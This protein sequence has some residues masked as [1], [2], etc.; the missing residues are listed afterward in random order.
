MEEL[1]AYRDKTLVEELA[2]AITDTSRTPAVF[3]EVCGTHTM[4]IQR[5]GLRSLLPAHTE[6]ISGPGCPVCVTETG[7]LD[8]AIAY[9]RRDEVTIATFGDMLRVPGS[10]S[11]L[12]RERARGADV[13]VVYS[14]LEAVALARES[15]E[16]Q[17]VFLGI[18][19]E[20]TAPTTA[21]AVRR[22][23]REGLGNFLVLS[24]H[25]LMKPAM[26]ALME[27]G[28]AIHG[29][30][31][32][33]HVSVVTGTAMYEE[34]LSRYGVSC[35]VAGFEPV[36]ILRGVYL[37][38]RSIEEAAPTVAIAYRRAVTAAGNRRAQEMMREVFE[39]CDTRWRGIGRI[40]HSGLD[41]REAY[42]GHDARRVAP[43]EVPEAREPDGCICGAV[44][45]GAAR[46]QEC[47][48][49]AVECTPQTPVGACMVSSEGTCAAYYRYGAAG[50][51]ARG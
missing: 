14:S 43:V 10:E 28:T 46:P 35:V 38:V 39:P 15:P 48:L 16:R 25:K 49:F 42:A 20:T 41:L 4:A 36:D 21:A 33:G 1:R 18:G 27:A 2:G 40:P 8:E 50:E 3:M 9:A 45:T 29:Y 11:T 44:L 47:R 34:L 31:C 6:L 26:S 5:Y 51:V 23:S 22:A 12:E 37:L 7:Y 24:A 17:V 13:R 32:P 19:F 30:L